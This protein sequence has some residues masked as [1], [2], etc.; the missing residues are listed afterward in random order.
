MSLRAPKT[1]WTI[2]SCTDGRLQAFCFDSQVTRSLGW[3]G[4]GI[5]IAQ[6]LMMLAE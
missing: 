4:P 1:P 6:L 2:A 3:S 5:H